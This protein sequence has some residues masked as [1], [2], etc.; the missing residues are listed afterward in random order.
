[1]LSSMRQPSPISFLTALVSL[2]PLTHACVSLSGSLIDDPL[3]GD[4]LSVTLFDKNVKTCDGG[5]N[6]FF[7]NDKSVFN[8]NC[9]SGYS[10]SL[11]NN[12]QSVTYGTPHGT[13]TFGQP[14]KESLYV[15]EQFEN[16]GGTQNIKC[17]RYDFSS[18][19]GCTGSRAKESVLKE[20]EVSQESSWQRVQGVSWDSQVFG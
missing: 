18:L 15:C 19:W 6:I 11:T 9:I 10:L 7:S 1:M 5:K 2:L 14:T 12:A 20:N 13:F 3:T 17:F 8:I 16:Q 4:E